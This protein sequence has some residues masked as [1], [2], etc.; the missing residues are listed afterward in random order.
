[1][2]ISLFGGHV[3]DF[4]SGIVLKMEQKS[5]IDCYDE[6]GALVKMY[7]NHSEHLVASE[8]FK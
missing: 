8:P 3:Y 6:N 4:F 7:V 2:P 1:M 5:T